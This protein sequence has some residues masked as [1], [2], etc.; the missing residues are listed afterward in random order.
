M[1]D[2]VLN[3]NYYYYYYYFHDFG[4]AWQLAWHNKQ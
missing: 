1:V 4:R 3:L 2:K